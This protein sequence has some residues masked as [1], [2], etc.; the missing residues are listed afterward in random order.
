MWLRNNKQTKI[1]TSSPVFETC[2]KIRTRIDPVLSG[3]KCP[4]LTVTS[5]GKSEGKTTTT[6]NLA[7][8]YAQQ[9]KRVLLIDANLR[10]P[11]FHKL[12]GVSNR[13]GLS[14][15]SMDR[16]EKSEIVRC[17][18]VPNLSLIT[19]GPD[20]VDPIQLL[21]SVRLSS[22]LD[23]LRQEY[24]IIFIDT[25]AALKWSDA[26]I[27]ASL[28]DGVLLVIKEGKVKK[29][30]ALRLKSSMEEIRA[31]IVGAVFHQA[32]RRKASF[33]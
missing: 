16:F 5:A 27:L 19:S 33:G 7:C 11:V 4:V 21:T 12:F 18:K 26:H 31:T 1:K 23:E 10:N 13:S 28:S 25:P 20:L 6:V 24:D 32:R 14:N 22:F 15:L 2:W 17:S 3:I 9:N 8:T 30:A 29:E